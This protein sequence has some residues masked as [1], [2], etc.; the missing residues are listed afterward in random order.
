MSVSVILWAVISLFLLGFW[1]WTTWILYRQK[2]AW[3]AYAAKRKMRYHPGRLYDSP[4]VGGAIDEYK[5]RIF[6][7][8]HLTGDARGERRLTTIEISLLTHLPVD[9]AVA[10]GGMVRIV[11]DLAFNQE[12]RPDIKGWDD[13]YIVRSRDNDR[14]RAYLTDE[15]L[16]A[17]MKLMRLKNA[18]VILIFAVNEGLLRV[19]TPDPLEDS[20]RL[21]ETVRQMIEAARIFELDKGEAGRLASQKSA[22]KVLDVDEDAFE[23]TALELEDEGD[24]DSASPSS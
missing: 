13:S 2:K 15:R 23:A 3:K 14:M 24:S 16:R 10:S 7:S 21:D 8:T 5:I 12:F 1:A 9:G 17:L 11:D 20:A 4:H 18:W 22:G 19:D 6:P